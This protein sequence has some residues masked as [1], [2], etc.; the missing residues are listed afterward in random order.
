MRAQWHI[1]LLG[2]VCWIPV[3]YGNKDTRGLQEAARQWLCQ[4]RQFVV[5]EIGRAC[6]AFLLAVQMISVEW[7][8]F[9]WNINFN[10]FF[11]FECLK[12]V[13]YKKIINCAHTK[14]DEKSS[15]QQSKKT[16]KWPQNWE[17]LPSLKSQP[18]PASS[19][20]LSV[21]SWTVSGNDGNDC[22][23]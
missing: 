4:D 22:G 16:Q 13:K 17:K 23:P 5:K 12:T 21:R 6:K 10:D 7:L 9:C 19:S 3:G 20:V 1:L 14:F 8:E 15:M 18:H 2:G 11:E